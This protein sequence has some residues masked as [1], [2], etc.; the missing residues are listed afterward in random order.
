MQYCPRIAIDASY[1]RLNGVQKPVCSALSVFPAKK[2]AGMR[3][4]LHSKQSSKGPSSENFLATMVA[5]L[6]A[7]LTYHVT[8]LGCLKKKEDE[9][10]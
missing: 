9:Q 5:F 3:S 4:Q 8:A 6:N 7:T 10:F 1:P 2:I